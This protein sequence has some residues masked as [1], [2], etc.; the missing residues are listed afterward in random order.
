MSI[1]LPKLTVLLILISVYISFTKPNNSP[2]ST[3]NR[4]KT[5]FALGGIQTH[6]PCIRDKRLTAIPRRP[7]VRNRNIDANIK[8]L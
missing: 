2:H 4:V 3:L 6:G 8:I 1:C 7:H 5:N